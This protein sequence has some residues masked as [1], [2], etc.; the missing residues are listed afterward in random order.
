VEPCSEDSGLA[1]GVH[2]ARITVGT[3]RDTIRGEVSRCS[4]QLDEYMGGD[5]VVLGVP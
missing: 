5:G 3:S 1:G 2:R 4:Q